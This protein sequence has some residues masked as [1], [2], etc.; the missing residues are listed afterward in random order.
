MVFTSVSFTAVSKC[1]TS[2]KE[3]RHKV[4][5]SKHTIFGIYLVKPDPQNVQGV[6]AKST[7]LY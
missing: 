5:P 2:L 4:Y 1:D 6:T 3:I 7:H